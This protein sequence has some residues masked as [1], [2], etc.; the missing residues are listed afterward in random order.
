MNE[1]NLLI[2]NI[3]EKY[4]KFQD[5]YCLVHS[6]F[7]SIEEQSQLAGFMRSHAKDGVYLYGGYAEAERRMVVFV[8][9]YALEPGA[10]GGAAAGS[11]SGSLADNAHGSGA[12]GQAAAH[13]AGHPV[14]SEASAVAARDAQAAAALTACFAAADESESPIAVLEATIPTAEHRKLTH[15]DYLGALM[16][17]GIK[18]EKVGD[19]L[20]SEKGAKIIV[21]TELADYLVQNFRQVGALSITTKR[22]PLSELATVEIKT[23][24]VRF[25]VSSLRIDNVLTGLFGISRKDAQEYIAHGRVFVSGREI[26]KPDMTLKGGEKIVL[27]GKGKAI[28]QGTSGTSKKGKLYVTCQKYI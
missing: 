16:G 5:Y 24:S 20:V 7:L 6:D 11:T 26:S 25:S 28:F 3:E 19:I 12:R 13:S 22:I 8:P 4:Q 15:R 21:A 9:D 2:K 23:E 27:R 14:N 18:R 1:T 17:E 10:G